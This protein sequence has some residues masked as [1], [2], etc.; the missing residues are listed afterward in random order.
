MIGFIRVADIPRALLG[1]AVGIV[2][3]GVFFFV[4]MIAFPNLLKRTPEWLA[5]VVFFS[6]IGAGYAIGSRIWA[7]MHSRS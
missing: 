6:L 1:F 3:L 4:P 2:L 7:R 5:G